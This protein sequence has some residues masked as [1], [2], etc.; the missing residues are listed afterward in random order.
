[1]TMKIQEITY[2]SWLRGYY[3]EDVERKYRDFKV[4]NILG[5]LEEV[6]SEEGE[7]FHIDD[8]KGIPLTDEML[9]A[10]GWKQRKYSC[11][12]EKEG[13]PFAL[14]IDKTELYLGESVGEDMIIYSFLYLHQ[15]QLA[16]TLCGLNELAENFKIE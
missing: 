3:D 14:G 11:I 15:L 13:V 9:E 8:C 10:D 1:M 4:A 6:E 16:Y 5:S 2:G 7:I 12:Y